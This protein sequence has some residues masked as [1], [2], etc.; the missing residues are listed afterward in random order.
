MHDSIQSRFSRVH[1]IV[2]SRPSRSA[3]LARRSRAR[4]RPSRAR[5]SAGPSGPS[6]APGVSAIGVGLPV[7]SLISLG[8]LADRGL[9]AAGEVVDARPARRARRR[10]AGR[11][12]VVDVDEVAGGDAAVLDRQRLALERP[13]DERRRDVAPDR[14]RRSRAS[15]R[16]RGPRRAR[17]R[18]GSAPSRSAARGA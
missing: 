6:R 9:D 7:S 8:Q 16:R 2:R 4:A 13:V 14:V 15:G 3:D 18:S 10:R 17:R 1:S 5:R 11:D 12:D